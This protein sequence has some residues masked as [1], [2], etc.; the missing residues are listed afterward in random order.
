MA[1]LSSPLNLELPCWEAP[2]KRRLSRGDVSRILSSHQGSSRRF[3]VPIQYL[4]HLRDR[5]TREDWLRSPA[6]DNLQELEFRYGSI[7]AELPP[8]QPPSVPR[9]SSTLR[10]ANFGG[11]AGFPDGSN[12]NALLHL[13]V[14]KQ[15][16]LWDVTIS[17]TSLNS[18]LAGCPV[19]QSLLLSH[20]IDC[21]RARIVSP[22]LRSLCVIMD[23]IDGKCLKDCC[24]FWSRVFHIG[25]P[26]KWS[27]Q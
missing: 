23:V 14:L 21:P 6:L 2:H 25:H 8:P 10:V 4:L 22:T 16:S 17:E 1:L 12:A 24:F 26:W 15:L 19:L 7:H 5:S 13:P 18:L 20:T 3:S 27:S 11:C 9:F